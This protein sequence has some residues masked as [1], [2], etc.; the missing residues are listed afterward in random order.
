MFDLQLTL[1]GRFSS[2]NDI[3]GNFSGGEICYESTQIDYKHHWPD[4][5]SLRMKLLSGMGIVRMASS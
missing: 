2:V 5:K 1:A 4:S 3:F